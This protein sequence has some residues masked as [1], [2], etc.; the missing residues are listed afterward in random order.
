MDVKQIFKCAFLL[1]L[2]GITAVSCVDE[3]IELEVQADVLIINKKFGDVVK[4]AP[5]YY[6][7]GNQLLDTATVTPPGGAA[8]GL[9]V[10]NGSALSRVLEPQESD[11]SENLP[12]EGN[13]TFSATSL[14]GSVKQAIDVVDYTGI[15]IPPVTKSTFSGTPSVLNVE[16]TTVTGADGYFLKLLDTTGKQI[17]ASHIVIPSV[18]DYIISGSVNSGSWTEAPVNGATYK[19]QLNAVTFDNEGNNS[20]N[21]YNISE[22]S[23]AEKQIVWGT[24]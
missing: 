4:R 24:N 20:E 8:I 3:E 11:F 15:P 5:A 12:A 16:W 22:L 14:S 9:K 2:T 13:Y 7:Y 1:L 21:I 18:D 6:V 23:V 17:F 19:L 10:F